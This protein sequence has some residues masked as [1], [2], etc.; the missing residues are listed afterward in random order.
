MAHVRPKRTLITDGASPALQREQ[1]ISTSSI[2]ITFA[3]SSHSGTDRGGL[4]FAITAMHDW[5]YFYP[6]PVPRLQ[7]SYPIPLQ[8][9][10]ALK[11]LSIFQACPKPS[12]CA[13][14]L[15]A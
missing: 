6:H 10:G 14:L 8:N 11:N 15:I 3:K 1:S 2:A 12:Q 13:G 7:S 4:D 5:G 9:L